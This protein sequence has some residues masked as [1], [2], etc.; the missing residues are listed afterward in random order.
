MLFLDPFFRMRCLNEL[1]GRSFFMAKIFA[2][3]ATQ[4]GNILIPD[5]EFVALKFMIRELFR[6]L[7]EQQIA[8]PLTQ[9]LSIFLTCSK[10]KCFEGSN[11]AS[12]IFFGK[13]IVFVAKFITFFLHWPGGK[14]KRVSSFVKS[15]ARYDSGFHGLQMDN[16]ISFDRELSGFFSSKLRLRG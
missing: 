6:A 15:F 1:L 14:N 10:G 5:S 11:L 12:V 2:R 13:Q 16:F 9:F 4:W 3:Y 7:K 8:A